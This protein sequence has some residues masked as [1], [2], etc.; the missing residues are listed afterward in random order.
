MLR[1]VPR[2][3]LQG[4]A[5]AA[6]APAFVMAADSDRKPPKAN[7]RLAAKYSSANLN[8]RAYGTPTQ[9]GNIYGIVP[10][11]IGKTDEFWYSYRSVKGTNYWRVDPVKKTKVALF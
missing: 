7:Y 8:A 11:W 2:R 1:T 5:L 6:L 3:V 9:M 4:L 10:N